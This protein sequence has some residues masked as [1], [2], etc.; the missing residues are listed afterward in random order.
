MNRDVNHLGNLSIFWSESS[1]YVLIYAAYATVVCAVVCFTEFNLQKGATVGLSGLM[2]SNASVA[3]LATLLFLASLLISGWYA[4]LLGGEVLAFLFTLIITVLLLC[5][6]KV[7]LI[8]LLALH[9]ASPKLAAVYISAILVAPY[10]LFSVFV[11]L[12]GSAFSH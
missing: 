9:Y 2:V 10:T 8:D 4:R 1:T 11:Y 12:L 7:F 3:I 5:F 6:Y